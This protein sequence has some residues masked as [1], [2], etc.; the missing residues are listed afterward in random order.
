MYWFVYIAQ[1]AT[2]RYYV[3]IT[4]NPQERIKKHNSGHGSQ[5]AR[6]QGPLTLVYVS[7]PLPSK[8]EARKREMQ[9]KG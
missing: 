7:N 1:A 3:G 9:L 2:S 4:T 5:F 8:S 6:Q